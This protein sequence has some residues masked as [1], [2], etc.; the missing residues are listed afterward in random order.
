MAWN[1][2]MW[3]QRS[4]CWMQGRSV[5]AVSFTRASHCFDVIALA[6]VGARRPAAMQS[7]S[8]HGYGSRD[9]I[10]PDMDPPP[11]MSDAEPRRNERSR[12]DA[13][14]VRWREHYDCRARKATRAPAVPS[15][16]S[17]LELLLLHPAADDV[18]PVGLDREPLRL[19]A[20]EDDGAALAARAVLAAALLRFDRLR[21][22]GDPC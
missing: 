17:G 19:Q 15:A 12:A 11:R 4:P 5:A 7:T 16:A 18:A 2:C 8:S 6:L 14:P 3:F 13:T 20:L 21:R 9:R 10:R 1:A 22:H